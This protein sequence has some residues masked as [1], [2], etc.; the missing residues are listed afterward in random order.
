[1]KSTDLPGAQRFRWPVSW[2]FVIVGEL[3]LIGVVATP[4]VKLPI[5]PRMG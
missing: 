2:V 1:L 4:E 5:A 3:T